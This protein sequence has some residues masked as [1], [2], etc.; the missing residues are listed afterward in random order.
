LAGV[1]ECAVDNIAVAGLHTAATELTPTAG[2][3]VIGTGHALLDDQ[4]LDL[5]I[6]I[7]PREPRLAHL[8]RSERYGCG[9]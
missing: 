1:R 7:Y 6:Y 9:M 8:R 2:T 5:A 4:K 3:N